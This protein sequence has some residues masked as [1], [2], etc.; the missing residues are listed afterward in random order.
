VSVIEAQNISQH[1][2]SHRVASIQPFS[3]P[4]FNRPH[5]LSVGD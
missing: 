5:K 3:P 2:A 4:T 1:E